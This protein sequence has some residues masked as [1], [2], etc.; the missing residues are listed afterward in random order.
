MSNNFQAFVEAFKLFSEKLQG[1][2]EPLLRAA[3]YLIDHLPEE[4][5]THKQ[6]G[7]ENR[8]DSEQQRRWYYWKVRIGELENPYN[9]THRLHNSFVTSP[10][11]RTKFGN[12]VTVFSDY[13]KAVFIIGD[14]GVSAEQAAVHE[15]RWWSF[16][17]EVEAM[18]DQILDTFL[19]SA[20]QNLANLW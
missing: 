15:G 7:N 4:P 11:T 10:V 19:T 17:A 13:P 5:L 8:W 14:P 9:R 6:S 1:E 3:N 2:T 16:D 20:D 12:A 18:S